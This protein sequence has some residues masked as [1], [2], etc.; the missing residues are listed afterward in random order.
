MGSDAVSGD[1]QRS[2]T[3]GWSCSAGY[4]RDTAD[5]G[6]AVAIMGFWGIELWVDRS[7]SSSMILPAVGDSSNGTWRVNPE[8]A[9]DTETGEQ[10][11]RLQPG[12]CAQS[13]AT[14][15]MTWDPGSGPEQ[16]PSLQGP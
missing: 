4:G 16:R 8:A 10:D 6:S 13:P 2:G 15:H 14:H 12:R 3:R 11:Q 9:E 5:P 7:T 1:L